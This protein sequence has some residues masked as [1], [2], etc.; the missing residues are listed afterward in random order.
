MALK[1]RDDNWAESYQLAQGQSEGQWNLIDLTGFANRA[2]TGRTGW[3]GRSGPL[4]Y[5]PRGVQ[6]IHGVPFQIIE[7]EEAA[8]LLAT[9]RISRIE[10]RDDPQSVTI[11]VGG[12][13]Q[14]VYVLHAAAWATEHAK[15]G[16]YT[17][18]YTDGT[19]EA[20]DI[21]SFGQGSEHYDIVHRLSRESNIQ[22]W[23]PTMMQFDNDDAR[24]VLIIDSKNPLNYNR[25]LYTLQWRNPHPDR[26][27]QSVEISV[28]PDQDPALFVLAM[29]ALKAP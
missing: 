11:P 26:E 17:F 9:N 27:V 2:L 14:A 18:Q 16:Q 7:D 4:L 15:I 25:Y 1:Q 21:V 24:Q 8:I 20:V 6:R 12:K 19:H 13:V 3:L 23:Y 5:M 28:M 10:E 29:T 22:D